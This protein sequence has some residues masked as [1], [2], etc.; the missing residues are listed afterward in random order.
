M[1]SVAT[2]DVTLSNAPDS[3]GPDSVVPK[4]EPDQ[5][6]YDSPS[7]SSID[8]DQDLDADAPLEKTST[9]PPPIPKRKGGRKPVGVP[10]PISSARHAHSLRRSM[11]LPRSGSKGTVKHRLPFVN[12]EP[13]TSNNSRVPSSTMRSHCKPY[14]KATVRLQTNV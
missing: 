2:S 13:S 9:D 7:G 11:Q 12:V 6:G 4:V 1:G 3:S 14:S 10:V 8:L 5:D